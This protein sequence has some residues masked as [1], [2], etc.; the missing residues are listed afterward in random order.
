MTSP[1]FIIVLLYSLIV[2]MY[3]PYYGPLLS[4]QINKELE[5]HN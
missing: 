1:L 5:L 2:T 4:I 3:L